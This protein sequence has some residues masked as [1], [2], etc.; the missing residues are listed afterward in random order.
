TAGGDQVPAM[1]EGSFSLGQYRRSI[2]TNLPF[3][4]GSQLDSLSLPGDSFCRYSVTEPSS[5]SF[6]L[7]R[8]LRVYRSRSFATKKYLSSYIVRDQKPSAGGSLPL[9]KV[10]VYLLAP[11]SGLPSASA[12]QVG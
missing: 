9:A 6:S 8:W 4:A 10:R 5:F 11:S 2:S 1:T 7:F 12:S 3:G